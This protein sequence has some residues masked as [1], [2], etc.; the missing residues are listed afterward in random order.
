MEVIMKKLLFLIFLGLSCSLIQSAD[1]EADMSFI[2]VKDDAPADLADEF[3]QIIFD[4]QLIAEKLR[5]DLG[6]SEIL[7]QPT[8]SL[9]TTLKQHQLIVLN[10]TLKK[11]Y[12][13]LFEYIKT[14]FSK[15]DQD[16]WKFFTLIDSQTKRLRDQ[17]SELTF[18]QAREITQPF[19]QAL[20][21]D[22][23]EESLKVIGASLKG[24][25][26]APY[27]HFLLPLFVQYKHSSKDGLQN[28]VNTITK[29]TSD[30]VSFEIM[31]SYF[32]R[33]IDQAGGLL[34]AEHLPVLTQS[35]LTIG[36]ELPA[37]E[38]ALKHCDK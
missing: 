32:R 36:L 18:D 15:V 2:D 27:G 17:W 37:V 14:E 4:D 16:F 20:K 11:D 33:Q 22:F 6:L 23:D 34:K 9:E 1:A 5:F 25:M 19:C 26:G 31:Q 13:G 24:K 10:F 30:K 21:T 7:K 12:E 8:N 29:W 38:D 3:E 35:L 28:F